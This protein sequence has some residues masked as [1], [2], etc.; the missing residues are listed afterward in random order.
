MRRI[1]DELAKRDRIRK[2][3]LTIRDTGEVNMF[4]VPNVERLAYYYNCHDLTEYIH[5]DR[6]GYLNLIMTGKFN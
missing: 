2:Q 4:D 5:E 6:A 3:V 1:E